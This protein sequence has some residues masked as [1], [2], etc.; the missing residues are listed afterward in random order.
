MLTGESEFLE[1]AGII[2]SRET[3]RRKEIRINTK[4]VYQQRK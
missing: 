4:L 3:W 2:V 1:E